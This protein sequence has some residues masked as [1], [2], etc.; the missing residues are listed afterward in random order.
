MAL[1]KAFGS[2]GLPPNNHLHVDGG[3]FALAPGIL[4]V[5][6]A[7]SSLE[8]GSDFAPPPAKRSVGPLILSSMKKCMLGIQRRAEKMTSAKTPAG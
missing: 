7:I 2:I 1:R 3:G 4:P 8:V 6:W 5:K